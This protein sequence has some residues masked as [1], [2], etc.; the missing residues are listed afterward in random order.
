MSNTSFALAVE[1]FYQKTVVKVND[2]QAILDLI[3]ERRNYLNENKPP[4]KE[5]Y[6]AQYFEQ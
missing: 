2:Q 5:E 6:Y 4:T 3:Q 1:K